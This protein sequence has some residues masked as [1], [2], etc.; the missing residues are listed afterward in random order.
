MKKPMVSVWKTI[1]LQTLFGGMPDVGSVLDKMA[2]DARIRRAIKA[3]K[4]PT[5][6]GTKAIDPTSDSTLTIK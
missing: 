6:D 3:G 4:A 2:E 5:S 1:A